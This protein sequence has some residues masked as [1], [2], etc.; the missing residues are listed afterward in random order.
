[1][2]CLKL[3]KLDLSRSA[4]LNFLHKRGPSIYHDVYF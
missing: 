3:F 2:L 1:M 4:E